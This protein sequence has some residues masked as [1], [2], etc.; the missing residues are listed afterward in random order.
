MPW[1]PPR[2]FADALG[3]SI[4]LGPPREV[5]DFDGPALFRAAAG[6]QVLQTREA[7]GLFSLLFVG[8]GSFPILYS[9]ESPEAPLVNAN[10]K[11]L[12]VHDGRIPGES[13]LGD[14]DVSDVT[15]ERDLLL[16]LCS[17]E[18]QAR[19]YQGPFTLNE[20][21]ARFGRG[22][23]VSSS[24]IVARAMAV[25][26]KNRLVHNASGPGLSSVNDGV[27]DDYEVRLDHSR[28][29]QERL[30]AL[31]GALGETSEL[32]MCVSD[33]SKAYRRFGVR[34]ADVPLL[35]LRADA[36]S[37]QT[38]PF[39]DGERLSERQVRAGQLLVFFDTRLPFGVSASVSSCVRVSCFVRDIVREKIGGWS[40][41]VQADVCAYI[42]DFAVFG[43]AR[44][45]PRAVAELR[46]L[47][48][49]AGCPENVAKLDTPSS[50]SV[51][52][53]LEYDLV[54]R[55][56]RLPAGRKVAYVSHLVSFLRRTGGRRRVARSELQSVVGKL[57]NASG[58]YPIGKVFY[59]R[60]LDALRGSHGASKLRLSPSALDDLR[61][62]LHLLREAPGVVSLTP[63]PWV[64]ENTHRVY[65]DASSTTGWGCCFE[66]QW[67]CGRWS[68]EIMCAIREKRVS[69]SDLELL[70]LNF[71]VETW[72]PALAGRRLLLRC[73]NMASVANVTSRSSR[74]PLRA[75]LLRRL[76]VFAAMYGIQLRSTYIN[77]KRNEHA[78]ALSRGDLRRFFALPQSYPLSQVAAPRL[79]AAGLLLDPRGPLDPSSP[80]FLAAFP[81]SSLPLP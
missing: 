46:A 60:L 30:R 56:V 13:I 14:G 65:T 61:W 27:E 2:F 76:F 31:F 41:A 68:A 11:R 18:V 81:C 78:D 80:A 39:F 6:L 25:T 67:M 35:A 50:L 40:Q 55:T 21:V 38:V 77:T 63:E 73:D 15:G 57:V 53:G 70:A 12:V 71:A 3:L 7:R 8:N 42:D 44:V 54:A 1:V 62:W 49:L 29:F 26:T 74:Q 58:V 9:R 72:G 43:D 24:F 22:I 66:G 52:L 48:Q 19:R 79:A 20:A 28:V 33:I 69:I 5:A 36:G 47:L 64:S 10:P 37:E 34:L 23:I 4:S 51:F 32:S 59:Q 75:A 16:S 45:V 17:A